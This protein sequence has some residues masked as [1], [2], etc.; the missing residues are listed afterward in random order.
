MKQNNREHK[1]K[2][3]RQSVISLCWYP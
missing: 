1:C 2:Y 3:P